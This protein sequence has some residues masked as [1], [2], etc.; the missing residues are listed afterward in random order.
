[1]TPFFVHMGVTDQSLYKHWVRLTSETG[2]MTHVIK[3]SSITTLSIIDQH[4]KQ[5]NT[6]K[7]LMY[8]LLGKFVNYFGTNFH[9]VYPR[10]RVNVIELV[11]SYYEWGT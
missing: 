1:M 6:C 3:T 4:N 11:C 8:S 7:V 2:T 9:N 5:H 10:P